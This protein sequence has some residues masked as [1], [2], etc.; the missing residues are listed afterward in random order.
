[1]M[2]KTTDGDK[3]VGSAGV[4]NTAL[5]LGIGALSL[6]LLGNKNGNLLDLNG[7]S[8]ELMNCK[9]ALAVEKS[10]RYADNIGIETFKTTVQYF[11]KAREKTELVQA[12]LLRAVGELDKKA[13]VNECNSAWQYKTTNERID[14]AFHNMR[15][16]VDGHFVPGELKIPAYRVCPKPMPEYNSWTEPTS[17]APCGRKKAE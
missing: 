6:V 15:E 2:I 8:D 10:E 11:E 17:S 1:M 16:Y 14:C 9:T 12:D 4:S 3:S 5:G 7:N 13:A